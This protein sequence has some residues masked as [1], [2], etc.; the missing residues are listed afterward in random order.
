MAWY[1]VV[2]GSEYRLPKLWTDKELDSLM[3]SFANAKNGDWV[4]ITQDV[5][6]AHI[7]IGPATTVHVMRRGSGKVAI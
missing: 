5:G 7:L 3:N 4:H 6:L 2:D 1:A